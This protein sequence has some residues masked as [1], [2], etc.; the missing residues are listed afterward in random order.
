MK[1]VAVGDTHGAMFPVPDGDVFVHVGDLCRRS[2]LSEL[3]EQASWIRAL[4][5]RH[6][7]VIAGNHDWPLGACTRARTV[8]KACAARGVATCEP[9]S[10]ER[11]R[12]LF[13]GDGL[14]YL[15]DSEITIDRVRFYGTPWQANYHEWT[16]NLPPGAPLDAI[17]GR[18]PDALDVLIT[19]VPPLGHGDR[20]DGGERVGDA[21]LL[22]RVERAQPRLHLFGHIHQDGGTWRLG[23]T[24]TANVTTWGN[25]RAPTVIDFD[26]ATRKVT[27]LRVPPAR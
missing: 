5:H 8:C 1:I 13:R 27:M 6:K 18:I 16:F 21:S 2:D 20:L 4:P 25:R 11:A 26:E 19:H 9:A 17:W 10:Q 23:E 3:E 12:D 22:A 14:T 7:L 15:E 24:T